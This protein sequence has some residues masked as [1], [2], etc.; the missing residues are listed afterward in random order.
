M[1]LRADHLSPSG[2]VHSRNRMTKTSTGP[3]RSP[4][5]PQSMVLLLSSLPTRTLCK[6]TPW[7]LQELKKEQRNRDWVAEVSSVRSSTHWPTLN[8]PLGL[9]RSKWTF[10]LTVRTLAR[11]RMSNRIQT[12]ISLIGLRYPKVAARWSRRREEIRRNE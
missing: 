10:N 9:P 7:H 4:E 2:L 12:G 11:K 3:P 6:R 5:I 1:T 8:F